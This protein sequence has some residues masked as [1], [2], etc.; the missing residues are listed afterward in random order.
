M[1]Q[2]YR[3]KPIIVTEE[4][5]SYLGKPRSV[6]THAKMPYL[7]YKYK[8]LDIEKVFSRKWLL[9]EFKYSM[10]VCLQYLENNWYKYIC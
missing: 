4:N 10:Y 2:I 6:A 8:G 7:K 9:A 5:N 1:A 3:H